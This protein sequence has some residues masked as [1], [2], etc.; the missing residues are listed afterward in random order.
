[1][2]KDIGIKI[3]SMRRSKN[4]S[5]SELA[6][7]AGIAQSTLSY[8]ENGKKTPHFQTLSAI[9]RGLETTVLKLLSYEEEHN[10]FKLFEEKT[11]NTV[12]KQILS[13]TEGSIQDTKKLYE[14]EEY[15]FN[16]YLKLVC[17]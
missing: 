15:L 10:D 5:Q 11:M 14:F 9:C 17:E 2:K 12:G 16:K 6:C 4:M 8:I 1:M 3:R 7:R 13:P